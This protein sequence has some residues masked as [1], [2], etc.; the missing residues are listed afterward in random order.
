MMNVESR[1]FNT[2]EKI[3]LALGAVIL[4][5]ALLLGYREYA[6]GIA[7]A[8]P[9]AWLFYRWQMK[10]VANPGDLS[11]QRATLRLVFRSVI[12]LFA[13]LGMAGFSFLG[14][15]LFFFGVL[16]GLFLQI[17]AFMGQ[18]FFIIIGKEG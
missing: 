18:A 3:M 12:R 2:P 4:S 8:A 15:E 13:F 9:V 16:T 7:I 6:C 1:T 10:A 17:L 5:T 11:P 14:G